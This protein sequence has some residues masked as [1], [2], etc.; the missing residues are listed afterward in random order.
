VHFAVTADVLIDVLLRGDPSAFRSRCSGT[1]LVS[2][3]SA[4][5]PMT[6]KLLMRQATRMIGHSRV[7]SSISVI[8]DGHHWVWASTKS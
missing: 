6:P 4:M 5:V 1:P 8:S 2:I 3:T 7:H